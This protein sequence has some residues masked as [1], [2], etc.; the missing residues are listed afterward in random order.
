MA[1]KKGRQ[2]P[3]LVVYPQHAFDDP[4]DILVFIELDGFWDD[5]KRLGLNDEEDMSTLQVAIMLEP[6]GSPVIPGTEGL[7]KMYFSPPG[8]PRGKRN[9]RNWE[10]FCCA[11]RTRKMKRTT[12][13]QVRERSLRRRS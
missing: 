8:Y 11:R 4:H 3:A 13:P 2:P 7:R 12:Y 1:R 10:S 5:W 6:K 9:F